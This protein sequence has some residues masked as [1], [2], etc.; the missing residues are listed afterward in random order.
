[1]A[2]PVDPPLATATAD[3]GGH[4][5]IGGLP[6]AELRVEVQHPDYPR[7]TASATPGEVA[8]IVVPVPGGVAGE[9]RA[10]A[11]GALALHARV[12][13]TGP[14]GAT[15][16]ADTQGTGTF[17]LLRLAPGAWHLRVSA[18]RMRAA[19][20]QLDVPSSPTMGEPSVRD[21]RIDLDPV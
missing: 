13:A 7:V 1:V 15:A 17:R 19:E 5:R 21:V 4:F 10:R 18:P 14:D 8:S 20:Q 11:T 6:P 9:V 3:V 16:S 2:Q 12:E